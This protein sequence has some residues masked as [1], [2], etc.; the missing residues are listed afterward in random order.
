M[1]DV[2]DFLSL[3]VNLSY[4]NVLNRMEM[5]L[6][7]RNVFFLIVSTFKIMSTVVK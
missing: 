1:K 2:D 6:F 7:F 3:N 5:K 4:V